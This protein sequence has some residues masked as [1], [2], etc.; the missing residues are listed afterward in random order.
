MQNE[1]KVLHYY[2]QLAN[3]PVQELKNHLLSYKLKLS[4]PDYN[5]FCAYLVKDLMQ[6]EKL[7]SLMNEPT[8]NDLGLRMS[9]WILNNAV[10][11]SDAIPR[12]AP[13]SSWA[14]DDES[15]DKRVNFDKV[16]D[17]CENESVKYEQL[18]PIYHMLVALMGDS[19]NDKWLRSKAKL[20]HMLRAMPSRSF[21]NHA[22][23][24]T[25]EK[26]VNQEIYGDR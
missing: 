20:I 25:I 2:L 11:P 15:L 4:Q 16:V 5:K 7:K 14:D 26:N 18:E 12:F 13:P 10:A 3:D 17:Y 24:V 9:K 19:S 21:V 23:E 1:A 22:D 8:L 6:D